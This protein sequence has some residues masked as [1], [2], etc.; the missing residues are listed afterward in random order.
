MPRAVLDERAVATKFG[1]SVRLARTTRR[2]TQAALAERAGISANYM[3]RL[4]RGEVAPSLF[5]AHRIARALGVSIDDLVVGRPEPP[6]LVRT[7]LASA[8]G[9][10]E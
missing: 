5:V 8:L 6:P 10:R 2:W 3:A 7:K 1:A 9:A 4:E